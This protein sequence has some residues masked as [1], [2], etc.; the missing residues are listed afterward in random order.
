VNEEEVEDWLQKIKQLTKDVDELE[1]EMKIYLGRYEAGRT[2]GI[3]GYAEVKL[4]RDLKQQ[5][6]RVAIK[7]VKKD[8]TDSKAIERLEREIKFLY[9]IDH[10]NIV[11]LYD[12]LNS[13]TSAIL[14]MEFVEGETLDE[15]VYQSKNQCLPEDVAR[16]LFRKVHSAVSYCHALGIVHRDLKMENIMVSSTG[17]LR[18]LDFGLGNTWEPGTLLETFCGTLEY[19]APEVVSKEKPYEGGPCDVWSL[20]V[21]LYVM[22]TGKFPFEDDSVA[23]VLEKM[24]LGFPAIEL[25]Q[26]LPPGVISL[27]EIIFRPNPKERCTLRQLGEHPWVL[28]ETPESKQHVLT[29]FQSLE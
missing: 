13:D 7:V 11:K 20:G 14:V 3:G 29:Y 1:E 8:L 17:D 22:L 21:I 9:E 16:F 4:G 15:F 25:Q 6:R 12:C 26:T 24:Q 10:P 23:A 27:F 5:D 28:E 19:A 2:I 18:L